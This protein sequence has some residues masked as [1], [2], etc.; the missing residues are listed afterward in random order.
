MY[1]GKT[2][3]LIMLTSLTVFVIAGCT[4]FE[5]SASS[6]SEQIAGPEGWTEETHSSDVDPNYEIVFP[7]DKVNQI[8]ITITPDDWEVMQANMTELFGGPGTSQ[9][10]GFPWPG[11]VRPEIGDLPPRTDNITWEQWPDPGGILPDAGVHPEMGEFFPGTDNFTQGGLPGP[12]DLPPDMEGVFPGGVPPEGGIGPDA[13]G[14]GIPGWFD[15]TPENPVWIPATIEFNG[16]T[17]TNVGI[18]Y[19]GNSSLT[20]GWRNGSLKLPLKL[21]FDEF[22]DEYTEI[23]NQRFYGFKQLSLS[24]AFNDRTYMRDVISADILAEAG[25]VAADTAYYEVILDYGEGPVNLGLYV[26]VEVVDDTVID[27]FFGDDSGNIYE[28]DGRAAS[29][30]QGTFSQIESSFLKENNRGDAD[31]SDIEELYNVLHS[32]SR[33]SEP[34]VWRESLESV[35]DVN[36]FLKWLTIAAVIQHW[37]TYGSMTHN[38][39]LYHDP[40]TGQLTWISWDHNMVLGAG[41]GGDRRG[42]MGAPGRGMGGSASL[43]REE[44]GQNWP[45][46]RYLLDDPV[47]YDRY[48]D[49]IEEAINGAFNPDKIAEKCQELAELI[50]PYAA[51]ESSTSDFN[52]AVQELINRVYE[53]FEAATTFLADGS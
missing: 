42:G 46:I 20:S 6:T 5:E 49:Y 23:D 2:I 1:G 36:T 51:Q 17:W 50:A 27:R 13:G 38:F 14:R 7:K 53:R 43:G 39:Y 3:C 22:E 21:D 41:I 33:T 8:K 40:D 11:G 52:S 9:Q 4:E 44:I 28:A 31:W 29:L 19:K 30:A 26:M 18:R 37:D 47:Y 32:E 10:G 45:L 12:R 48:V 35:F 34:E 16:F 24:N 15:M 25:L